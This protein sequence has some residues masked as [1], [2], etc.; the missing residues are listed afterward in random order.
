MRYVQHKQWKSSPTPKSLP[1]L[2]F[3][4]VIFYEVLMVSSY[5]IYAKC[6]MNKESHHLHLKIF[7]CVFVYAYNFY[8]VLMV[9]S[10]GIYTGCNMNHQSHVFHPRILPCAYNFYKVLIVSSSGIYEDWEWSCPFDTFLPRMWHCLL[11]SN[12]ACVVQ[13]CGCEHWKS[14]CG[15]EVWCDSSGVTE[16]SWEFLV[17][18]LVLD[19][20]VTS[21]GIEGCVSRHSSALPSELDTEYH[22]GND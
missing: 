22:H 14:P 20:D 1:V 2:F 15:L 16:F 19:T 10:Y 11:H 21:S 12:P 17:L 4:H 18:S 5:R 6:G 7:P 9:S 13:H 3:R 8:K